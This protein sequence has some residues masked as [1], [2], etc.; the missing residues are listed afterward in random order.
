MISN[1]L[2]TDFIIGDI[3]VRLCK[4]AVYELQLVLSVIGGND[5]YIF[6]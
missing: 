2:D 3:H 6:I 4:K 5:E 1:S